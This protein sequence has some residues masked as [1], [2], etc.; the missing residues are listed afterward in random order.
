MKTKIVLSIAIC[1][2]ITFSISALRAQPQAAQRTVRDAVYTE[3]QAARGEALLK[4]IGCGGCHGSGLEGG[5]EETPGLIGNEFVTSYLNQ[6]LNDLEIKVGSMPPDN[7]TKRTTQQNVD[8]V[9]LL[10]WLNG[11]PAGTTELPADPE[12]LSQIKVIFP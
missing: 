3:E 12:V 10:L 1:S 6:T 4:E 2:V 9:S 8:L 5:P 11:Y 7:R